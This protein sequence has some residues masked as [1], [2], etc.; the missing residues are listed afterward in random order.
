MDAARFSLLKPGA[1]ESKKIGTIE[2]EERVTGGALP[3]WHD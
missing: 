2:E 3:L 1:V